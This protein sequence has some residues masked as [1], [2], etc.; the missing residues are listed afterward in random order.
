MVMHKVARFLMVSG[1]EYRPA[2][3]TYLQAALA[4]IRGHRDPPVD[5]SMHCTVLEMEINVCQQLLNG[6]MLA[7]LDV[8][9]EAPH[10]PGA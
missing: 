5:T 4:L 6:Q 2:A 3:L 9:R 1:A 10:G 8:A 7:I